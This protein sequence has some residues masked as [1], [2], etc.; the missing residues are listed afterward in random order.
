[1]RMKR[2]ALLLLLA[3]AACVSPSAG[4]KPAPGP[5]L[6][7]HAKDLDPDA[8]LPEYPR[9]QLVRGRWENLNGLWQFQGAAAGEAAPCG[10]ELAE[11]ILVPFPPE[12][13]LSGIGRAVER[14]WYRRSFDVPASWRGE[15]VL[16]HF[17][18]VDWE[19]RVWVNGVEV[20]A[21]KGGYDPF[22]FDVTDALK[23]GRGQELVVGVVDPTDGGD[24]PR[25]KQVR[26]PGG[27][28]Y[29]STTGIW[30]TVWIE[31]VPKAHVTQVAVHG[32]PADGSATALVEA[33]GDTT[34]LEVE[35]V[36]K[37]SGRELARA[38]GR[39][40]APIAFVVPGA[41]GWTPDSPQLYDLETRLVR[42]DRVVDEARAY[43]ALRTIRLQKGA[44]GAPRLF[45]NGAECFQAG[46]LDQGFW[47]DGLY[48]APTDRAL[49]SDLETLKALGFNM[50]RKHVKV[51]P[52]RY[53]RHCDELGLLV[54]QDMP[55]GDN[56]SDEGKRQFERELAAMV[57]WLQPFP[58]IVCWVVFNEGWG[59]YDT[60]RIVAQVQHLDATRLVSNASGWV[61]HKVGD[62][63][64]I[65]SYPGPAAPA[66]EARRAAVLGEFGGI[67]LPVQGHTWEAK[68]WGYEGAADRDAL[69]T[70]YVDLL[71]GVHELR[72]ES[73]LAAAV[74]TQTTD[75]ETETNGLLTYDR[76]VLKPDMARVRA[77]NL[78]RFP[79]VV[80]LVPTSKKTPVE[81]KVR[82]DRPE[83]G[84]SEKDHD[85]RGWVSA[86]GV[87]GTRGTPGAAVQTEWKTS[88]IWLRRRFEL[89]A[90]ARGPVRLQIHHDED[91][92]V[93]L[94]GVLVADLKGYTTGYKL[95][96]LKPEHAAL[97]TQGSHVLAI[98]CH[99]TGG[100][101][102]IDA[103]FVAVEE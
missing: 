21:H 6:S 42:R 66:I 53:Y 74:Y 87:F 25:G 70:R 91:A 103:G 83:D 1:M 94:D 99:Q 102:C 88:D 76:A 27:I 44:D 55:S 46:P 81:W 47:P 8:P 16:L 49:R 32:D 85:D 64:D 90:A 77:A 73:G 62:M 10:T 61:D 24:Q 98:H 59:Q 3:T 69:T 65:H 67:G 71:R 29:T 30:Q 72:L 96:D 5:L 7:V 22:S 38:K 39:A 35:L 82:F 33:A 11:R 75:V 4:W 41:K 45:L 19:A 43:F 26:Q 52:A 57:R 28:F 2:L 58:S 68:N 100:G 60:P 84:W 63:M 40:G 78:G 18:A 48:T 12:S 54:W 92:Q 13:Q 9:P 50:L 31:P 36:V 14:A 80:P 93:W 101:Q 97:L 89:A 86:P 23:P 95:V 51:E 17:G 56:R 34:D 15:R 79:K 37:D 20:G